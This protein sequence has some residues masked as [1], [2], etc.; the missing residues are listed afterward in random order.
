MRFA[1]L[2]NLNLEPSL[3][4]VLG[5]PVIQ[6]LMARDGVQ[7]AA[8][9]AMIAEARSRL[10]QA[11]DQPGAPGSDRARSAAARLEPYLFRARRIS[12]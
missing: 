11:D 1:A 12:D 6:A 7:R 10:R 9:L 8:L 5:D 2:R 3:D 4:D